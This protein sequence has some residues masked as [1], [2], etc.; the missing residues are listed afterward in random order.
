M[1]NLLNQIQQQNQTGIPLWVWGLVV[2]I[3]IIVAVVWTLHEEGEAGSKADSAALKPASPPR[4]KPAAT[5][6]VTAADTPEATVPGKTEAVAVEKPVAEAKAPAA[7][8]VRPD[9]LKRV[10]GIGPKI[11]KLLKDNGI[12]TFAQLAQT[13]VS[14]IQAL[15]DEVEYTLADPATWPEQARQLAAGKS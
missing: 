13:E 5:A 6:P 1:G 7:P 15:L 10:N 4:S 8:Q 11:E 12:T 9:N 3:I 2:L 14:R